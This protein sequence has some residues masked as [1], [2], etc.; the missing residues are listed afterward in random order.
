MRALA[1]CAVQK[2]HAVGVV[3]P[4]RGATKAV[5]VGE[6]AAQ[7][8]MPVA[9]SNH[10]SAAAGARVGRLC[11]LCGILCDVEYGPALFL[12]Q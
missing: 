3:P 12:V 5:A 11:L 9:V 2:T 1:E 8:T 6:E 4:P 7:T 10:A